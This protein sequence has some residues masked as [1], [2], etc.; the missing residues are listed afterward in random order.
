MHPVTRK[1]P[2][3]GRITPASKT[4]INSIDPI[5][6]QDRCA[7]CD[8][9]FSKHLKCTRKFRLS[10]IDRNTVDERASK[11]NKRKAEPKSSIQTIENWAGLQ[12]VFEW[13][14]G[15]RS[16]T[17]EL[18]IDKSI[19]LCSVCGISLA[20]LYGAIKVFQELSSACSYLELLNQKLVSGLKSRVSRKSVNSQDV[21][22]PSQ[23]SVSDD[24]E[25]MECPADDD[26][27][28]NPGSEDDEN[29][30]ERSPDPGASRVLLSPVPVNGKYL[31]VFFLW[32]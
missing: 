26:P 21:S 2:R 23:T 19:A 30:K 25:G 24:D 10:L 6:K 9:K 28:Y 4:E 18:E 3:S 22:Q 1:A 11:S 32:V 31:I 13:R 20:K 27:D 15:R 29:V 8:Q 12:E 7:N 16:L 5:L 17:D 14:Y